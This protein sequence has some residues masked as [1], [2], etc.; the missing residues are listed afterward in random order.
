MTINKITLS[1]I[2]R[3]GDPRLESD[4]Q[5]VDLNDPE[6]AQDIE[7]LSEALT[8]FQQSH[9]WGRS[10]AAPQIGIMKRLIAISVPDL[11][12]ILINPEIV[13]HSQETQIVWD[14]CMSLPEIAVEVERW[15]S[16]SIKF[17]TLDGREDYLKELSP[18]NSELLQHEIDHLNG[19][20]MTKRMTDSKQVISREYIA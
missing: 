1:S 9:Q 5:L 18:E 4:T 17:Q 6:L 2:L 14:D 7:Q 15:Q 16:I 13:W 20:I 3:F 19:I 12:Q 8:I 10:I 11:P